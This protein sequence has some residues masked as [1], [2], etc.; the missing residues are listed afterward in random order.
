MCELTARNGRGT[1]WAR[2]A[3]CEFAFNDTFSIPRTIY[4]WIWDKAEWW[5]TG[6]NRTIR[7]QTHSSATHISP[8]GQIEACE[9]TTRCNI[10]SY[11]SCQSDVRAC[12]GIIERSYENSRSSRWPEAFYPLKQQRFKERPTTNCSF[13]AKYACFGTNR[14]CISWITLVE[15]KK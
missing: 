2:H 6:R 14:V 8:W 13:T 10:F 1:A 9:V 11:G 7:K 5:L 4:D 3:M 15:H 12:N